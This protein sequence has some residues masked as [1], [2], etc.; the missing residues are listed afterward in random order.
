M[1]SQETT[2]G[3]VRRAGSLALLAAALNVARAEDPKSPLDFKVT[4]IDGKPVDLVEVQGQSRA[5]RER[6]QPLRQ[7]AAVQGNLE[8]LYK[9][10]ARPGLCRARLPGQR[11]RRQEPGTDAEIAE[12]CK[13]KYAST[14][15]CSPRSSSREKDRPAVRVPDLAQD[16]S[17]SMPARSSGTSRSSWSAATGRSWPA[18]SRRPNP[19]SPEVVKTIEGELAK[20]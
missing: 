4:S 2:H 19:E 12:F 10:Y 9:K 20:K 18:S 1:H 15:R 6:G 8:E 16:R 5:D 11:V 17:P 7:H 14:S 3:Q 13:T